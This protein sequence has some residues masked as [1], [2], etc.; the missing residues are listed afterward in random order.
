MCGNTLD[1]DT[2]TILSQ[3]AMLIIVDTSQEQQ[4]H[5]A[6]LVVTYV[7]K[8]DMLTNIGKSQA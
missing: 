6:I 3:T 8:P 1:D 2:M 7:H 4:Q 5:V